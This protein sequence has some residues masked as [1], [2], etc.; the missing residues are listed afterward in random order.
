MMMITTLAVERLSVRR[1]LGE[2]AQGCEGQR[3]R[4]YISQNHPGKATPRP[5]RPTPFAS[6]ARPADDVTEVTS[7]RPERGWGRE[8]D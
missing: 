6:W 5:R 3:K 8:A 1:E 2:G 4:N 7:R